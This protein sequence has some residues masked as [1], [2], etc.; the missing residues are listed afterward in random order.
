MFM[1][2]CVYKGEFN[3]N[4]NTKR[5]YAIVLPINI[6]LVLTISCIKSSL[7]TIQIHYISFEQRRLPKL[8]ARS[9]SHEGKPRPT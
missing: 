9:A 7:L 3:L 6:K 4:V 5:E 8:T 2:K 1:L